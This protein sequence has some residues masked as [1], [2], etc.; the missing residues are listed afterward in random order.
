MTRRSYRW[1]EVEFLGRCEAWP[2]HWRRF[3]E[4]CWARLRRI[5]ACCSAQRSRRHWRTCSTSAPWRALRPA[6]KHH[7]FL[8]SWGHVFESKSYSIRATFRRRE[9]IDYFTFLHF[10]FLTL[11]LSFSLFLFLFLNPKPKALWIF[12][13]LLPICSEYNQ[14]GLQLLVTRYNCKTNT[15]YPAH[16]LSRHWSTIYS[17][18]PQQLWRYLAP[19]SQ[20]EHPVRSRWWST[21]AAAAEAWTPAQSCSCSALVASR[22]GDKAATRIGI[23]NDALRCSQLKC[24]G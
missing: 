6:G 8:I 5:G 10:L 19:K 7:F 4:R 2:S 11:S 17:K 24:V 13:S 14:L 21:S 18:G 3:G 15:V 23:N 20:P 16:Q 9:K 12:P 1:A 22:S